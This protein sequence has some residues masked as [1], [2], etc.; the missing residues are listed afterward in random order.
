MAFA[1]IS[2]S[3]D[4]VRSA[5]IKEYRFDHSLECFTLYK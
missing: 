3:I 5:G 4:H 1:E 2:V